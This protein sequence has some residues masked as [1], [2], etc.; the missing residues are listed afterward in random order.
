LNAGAFSDDKVLAATPKLVPVMVDCSARGQNADLM[1]LYG[2][3]GFPTVIYVDPDGKQ[4]KEMDSREAGAIASEIGQVTARFPGRPSMWLPSV[5]TA[6]ELG[7]KSKKPVALY[8]ADPK[9]DLVKAN[10]KLMK[11]LGDRKTRFLWVLEPAREDSLK[12]YSLE[13]APAIVVLDPKTDE[14][15]GTILCKDDA[16]AEDLQKALDEAAKKLKK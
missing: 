8:L 7:K 3:S 2:V 15:L 12:K 6:V 10:A 16:K 4:I 1:K 11:D 14:V 5:K 9:A 13:T